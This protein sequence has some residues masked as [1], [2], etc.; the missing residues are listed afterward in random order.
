MTTEIV[1]G[2]RESEVEAVVQSL[3]RE[4]E[5]SLKTDYFNTNTTTVPPQLHAIPDDYNTE[6]RKKCSLV[7]LEMV[8]GVIG[9]SELES[10]RSCPAEGSQVSLGDFAVPASGGEHEHRKEENALSITP[11]E[12]A[13]IVSRG[14]SRPNSQAEKI[15][16]DVQDSKVDNISLTTMDEIGASSILISENKDE[17]IAKGSAQAKHV[18]P[19]TQ[20][21]H[22]FP[23]SIS[24]IN[25]DD[26]DMDE[27]TQHKQ[28]AHNKQITDEEVDEVYHS[29]WLSKKKELETRAEERA[30]VT[31]LSWQ[32]DRKSM[33]D[34][35]EG[36]LREYIDI[37]EK[38]H[39]LRLQFEAERQQLMST[40][41]AMLAS[42]TPMENSATS[43]L[44]NSKFPSNFRMLHM[45]FP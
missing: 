28:F 44:P 19:S 45:Y 35:I 32:R 30:K 43:Y 24:I 2:P 39:A 6:A 9:A 14:N 8:E 12:H 11:V 36:S 34:I 4:V 18:A 13:H 3:V 5:N 16:A 29:L 17:I 31:F 37:Y 23:V 26:G 15:N 33:E 40:V 41:N 20:Q 7:L 27:E 42:R 25:I 22:T 1:S 38:A 21:P 10:L